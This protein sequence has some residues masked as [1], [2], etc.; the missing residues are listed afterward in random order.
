MIKNY[1]DKSPTINEPSFIA[2]NAVIVGDVEIN[3]NVS[4]WYN[5]TL[6]GD[7]SKIII[8]EN[9]NVQENVVMHGDFDKDV[10][11]GKNVTIGHGAIVHGC[12]VEDDVLIGMGSVLLN[13]CKI[14]KGAVIAAGTVVAPGK[15]VPANM[16][17]MGNPMKVV[18]EV[19]DE[20]K[21]G[22]AK[23]KD[24]YIEL[25]NNHNK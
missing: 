13:G 24:L 11:I 2:E 10:V 15:E 18:K 25:G 6:R 22:I 1:L 3:K 12:V 16:V 19:S 5:V 23:N 14:G 9:S 17:A 4:I 7:V 8:G 21:K 20:L